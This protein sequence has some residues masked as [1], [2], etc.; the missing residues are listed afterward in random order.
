M[1]EL[2][3]Y[4]NEIRNSQMSKMEEEVTKELEPKREEMRRKMLNDMEKELRLEK[5]DE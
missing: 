5:T 2:S 1:K 4:R 3:D